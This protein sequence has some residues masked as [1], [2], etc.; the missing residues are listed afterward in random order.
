M[1]GLAPQ[2]IEMV[3]D[4]YGNYVFQKLLLS[5]SLEL[6]LFSIGKV[7]SSLPAILET[8]TGTHSMQ[9]LLLSMSCMDELYLYLKGI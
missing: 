5:C 2:L 3:T 8:K 1:Y 9:T 6:R 7:F 4:S